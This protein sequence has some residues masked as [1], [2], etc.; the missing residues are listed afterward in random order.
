MGGTDVDGSPL[1]IGRSFHEGDTIPAKVVPAQRIAYIAYGG[2]EIIKDH[3]EVL[4]GG[5]LSWVESGHGA[6]PPNAVPAGTTSAGEMLYIG[7][8]PFQG[9]ITPGKVHPSNGCLYIPFNG[10]EIAIKTYEILVEN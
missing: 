3:Y 7:R 9:T 8:T 1:F 5:N 6:V 2:Q 4:C 10:D